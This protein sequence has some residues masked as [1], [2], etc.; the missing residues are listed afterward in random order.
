MIVVTQYICATNIL[1]GT[2]I[3]CVSLFMHA[4]SFES[5]EN[6]QSLHDT[7]VCTSELPT[8]FYCPRNG[9]C[10]SKNHRGIIGTLIIGVTEV[11]PPELG[12]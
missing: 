7:Y 12:Y 8:F 6:L 10:T 4:V 3:K 5:K 9:H 2:F 1:T 11:K